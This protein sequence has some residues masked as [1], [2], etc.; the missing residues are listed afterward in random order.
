[1]SKSLRNWLAVQFPS[2]RLREARNIPEALQV[3]GRERI[4]IA[5]MDI[6]LPGIDGIE[7]T[8]L[9]LK[10]DPDLKVIAMSIRGGPAR[11]T[12]ALNAGALEFVL[13][14]DLLKVLPPLLGPWLAPQ[15]D[16]DS[17]PP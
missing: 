11:R 17:P 2:I 15:T 13:K 12:A 9:L 1:M 3:V 4:S 7:G 6:E 10:L 8:R 14:A 5:L 16:S